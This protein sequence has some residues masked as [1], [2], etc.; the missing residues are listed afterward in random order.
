MLSN[1]SNNLRLTHNQH[2]CQKRE[3]G[4]ITSFW[5]SLQLDPSNLDESKI[6][7]YDPRHQSLTLL[8]MIRLPG[9]ISMSYGNSRFY[10][11][12]YRILRHCLWLTITK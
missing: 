12:N 3:N 10:Y 4:N 6:F 1:M 2:E 7:V 5:S 8:Q 9:R 11:V